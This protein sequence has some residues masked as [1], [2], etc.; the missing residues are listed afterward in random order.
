MNH[1]K[2]NAH[3]AITTNKKVQRLFFLLLVFFLGLLFFQTEAQFQKIFDLGDIQNQAIGQPTGSLIS[4]GTY[5]YGMTQYGGQYNLGVIFKIKPEGTDFS[6]IFDFDS[7]N[8]KFPF[9]SLIYDGSF[10]YGMTSQGGAYDHG[11][12]F[13]VKTDGTSFTHLK[14]LNNKVSEAADAGLQGMTPRGSLLFDPIQS[15]TMYGLVSDGGQKG[16]GTLFRINTNGTGFRTLIFFDCLTTGGFPNG[17]LISDGNFLYGMTNIAGV[18]GYGTL[19]KVSTDGNFFT[20]LLDLDGHQSGGYPY[21]DLYFDGN[22]LYAMTSGGGA[23]SYGTILKVNTD[24]SGYTKLLDFDGKKSGASPYGSLIS[25][26]GIFLYGMTSYGG[27]NGLGTIFRIKSD[28]SS[29]VKLH[30]FKKS[31]GAYPQGKLFSDKITLYG[32]TQKGGVNDMGSIFKF[33]NTLSI[34]LQPTNQVACVGDVVTFNTEASG[35]TKV[36]YQWQMYNSDSK[37]YEDLTTTGG[38]AGVRTASLLVNTAN[39]FGN[40][41]YR[42]KITGDFSSPVY[43]QSISLVVNTI[44]SVPQCPDVIHCGPGRVTLTT[45]GGSIGNYVWYDQ[46]N[47]IIPAQSNSSFVTPVLS[48]STNF[49]VSAQNGNCISAPAL[50]KVTIHEVP[51]APETKNASACQSS[52]VVLTA[53]GASDG[54]YLWYT[55]PGGGKPI[56]GEVNGTLT[57]PLLKTT[58]TYYAAIN[59]GVCE[60]SRTPAVATIGN[61]N[62]P[63]IQSQVL[64]TQIGGLITIDLLPLIHASQLNPASLQIISSPASGVSAAINENGVLTINYKDNTFAGKE[65][66]T[67]KACDINGL[68]STKDFTIEVTGDIIVYN[69]VS[70]NGAN[71]KLII[72]YIDVFNDTKQ[73][74]VYIF[75]RW[76]NLVWHATNY[77]NTG[78]VFAGQGDGGQELP[79]GIYFYKIDF[80][81]GRKSKTGFISLKR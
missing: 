2:T 73:N 31:D 64:T 21:G 67:I 1:K 19:F 32:M 75:D 70:P 63:V 11:I 12:V 76:Q 7:S 10:L 14:D 42:C 60:S 49:S 30:D 61:C 69:G 44:P 13:K 15:T 22:F 81:S 47:Q 80:S 24:G 68:C 51:L 35:S 28:G 23:N 25:D 5:L 6:K 34:T 17:S 9:G 8:G 45:N 3:C 43:T 77:D 16:C 72:Q 66:L 48:A 79:A 46:N 27:E 29:Y 55:L 37:D 56:V 71:P 38:F 33:S 52:A 65:Y 59:N 39:Q 4:D 58:T 74:A 54:A 50:V 62:P 41:S 53:S 57:T 78:V 20:S 36:I 18:Y 26:D 40:G